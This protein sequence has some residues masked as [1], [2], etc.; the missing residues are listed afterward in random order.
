MCIPGFSQQTIS[1]SSEGL[2]AAKLGPGNPYPL[3]N[4]TL[5]K[6]VEEPRIK[7]NEYVV[8]ITELRSGLKLFKE[9]QQR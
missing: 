8:Q 5:H 6:A 9:D 1:S 7:S 4:S 2:I 3:Y